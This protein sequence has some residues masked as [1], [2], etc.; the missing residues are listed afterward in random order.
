MP[1][2]VLFVQSEP[3]PKVLLRSISIS[4]FSQ[5]HSVEAPLGFE[6]D[7]DSPTLCNWQLSSQHHNIWKHQQLQLLSTVHC[8][9]HCTA[10]TVRVQ[11]LGI[12]LHC[13]CWGFL[14]WGWFELHSCCAWRITQ[15]TLLCG[16]NILLPYNYHAPCT[17]Q[18]NTLQQIEMSW[19]FP[20]ITLLIHYCIIIVD[21]RVLERGQRF[22]WCQ[23]KTQSGT[24][25]PR[26]FLPVMSFALAL[27]KHILL[28]FNNQQGQKDPL[29][30]SYFFSSVSCAP[31]T[32]S[33]VKH[34]KSENETA[35]TSP[36]HK[37]GGF[38]TELCPFISFSYMG[39]PI[40]E[41]CCLLT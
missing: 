7:S 14:W 41:M 17:L 6:P 4:I 36:A 24:L 8:Q 37:Y 32:R 35:V 5:W 16:P 18:R 11:F 31:D 26:P 1:I 27:I 13:C 23:G 15:P 40:I 21:L 39:R 22:C 10:C 2:S 33:R 20:H 28:F 19:V 30:C 25:I 29:I 34:S 12:T 38:W 9:A 3:P